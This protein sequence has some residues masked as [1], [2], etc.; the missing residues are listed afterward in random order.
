MIIKSK[1]E[2]KC[3]ES[4]QLVSHLTQNTLWE[5][6]K[7]TRKRHIQKRLEGQLRLRAVPVYFKV[8]RRRKPSSAEGTKWWKV[9]E[10]YHSTILLG[11]PSPLPPPPSRFCFNFLLRLIYQSQHEKTRLTRLRGFQPCKT[12]TILLSYRD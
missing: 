6:D 12:Q 10:K 11:S 8:V 9:L 4:I 1:E 3:Q 2:C 7:R 5:S